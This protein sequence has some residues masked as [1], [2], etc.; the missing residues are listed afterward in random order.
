MATAPK[1][2]KTPQALVYGGD[3][4]RTYDQHVAA[5]LE[6]GRPVLIYVGMED[7]MCNYKVRAS[8][9][10]IGSGHCMRC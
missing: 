6:A 1:Q 8:L 2:T 5:I 4:M 9:P 10:S 3:W 7:A